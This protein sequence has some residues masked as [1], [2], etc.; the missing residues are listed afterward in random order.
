MLVEPLIGLEV[1]MAMIGARVGNSV[2]LERSV[3][4][5]GPL[6]G[7][8]PDSSSQLIVAFILGTTLTT[9]PRS[10]QPNF[11]APCILQCQ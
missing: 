1:G 9:V 7:E 6:L 2:G 4:D 3:L 8:A 11:T 10:L 5:S